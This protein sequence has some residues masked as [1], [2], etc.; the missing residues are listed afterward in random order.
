[1]ARPNPRLQPTAALSA[2]AD[3]QVVRQNQIDTNSR[4][5]V[6]WFSRTLVSGMFLTI[7]PHPVGACD[8]AWLPIA[9]PP[10]IAF[11]VAT[12]AVPLSGGYR[13]DLQIGGGVAAT[14]APGPILLVPWRYGP[15]CRRIPWGAG[16]AWRPPTTAAFYTGRLRPRD[17][18]QAGLPT[19][20]VE[21]AWREPVWQGQDPRWPHTRPGEQLLTP[22]EFF[23][24]YEALPTE[25]DLKADP[26]SV[27]RRLSAWA[28]LHPALAQ[29][30]PARTMLANVRRATGKAG[31]N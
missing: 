13:A 16:Q 14:L 30:E 17:R 18:W 28:V 8:P 9:R 21:M 10:G 12:R 20:D 11:I 31:A 15:D 24:V 4:A 2:A 26:V 1:M 23:R 3:T 5:V 29:R 25:A 27:R 22:E 19:F 6:N 7:T